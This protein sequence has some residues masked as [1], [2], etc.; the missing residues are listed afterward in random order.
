VL[1]FD[2]LANATLSGLLLGG[3]YAGVAAGATIS[4]GLLDIANIAH[5]AFVVFGAYSAF[6]LSERLGLD[7][8][9]G[10]LIVIPVFFAAGWAVYQVYHFGPSSGAVPIRCAASPSSSASCSWARSS[11]S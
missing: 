11:S 1:S 10:A 2:L 6:V 9:L 4:F 3:F 5:P 8:L 7:P